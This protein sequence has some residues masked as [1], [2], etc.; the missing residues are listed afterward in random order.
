MMT[1]A[2]WFQ[3]LMLAAAGALSIAGVASGAE[4]S[5]NASDVAASLDDFEILQYIT[6]RDYPPS[7]PIGLDNNP[8]ILLACRDGASPDELR[9]SGIEFSDSQIEFLIVMNLLFR[10]GKGDLYTSFPIL[11]T[12]ET[13][14]LRAEIRSLA[15]DLAPL[16]LEDVA[17]VAKALAERGEEDYAYPLLFSYVLDGMFWGFMEEYREVPIRRLSVKRP[18]WSGGV[19]AMRPRRAFRPVTHSITVEGLT[20]K[21]V[22]TEGSSRART[23]R[24]AASAVREGLVQLAETGSVSDPANRQVLVELG[25]I[26]AGE[27]PTWSVPVVDEFDKDS[28][29]RAAEILTSN[30]VDRLIERI[31][32]ED[33]EERY[34]FRSAP[35]ALVI[36][37]HELMW[38]LLD[39]FEAAGLVTRPPAL[40][41]GQQGEQ[42]KGAATFT[43]AAFV[44]DSRP[45]KEEFRDVD[46]P[47]FVEPELRGLEKDG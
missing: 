14:K 28:V 15:A 26:D 25:V 35:E 33:L 30:L 18:F 7:L 31:D 22:S 11:D 45:P 2:G 29:F 21:V 38:D 39:H 9:A 23:L 1:K 8:E 43:G 32:L 42:Q 34:G 36:A 16:V 24:K 46:E 44:L 37:H 13:G 40:Q 47:R 17:A 27:E 19:W 10:D 20:L 3:C 5:A 12:T 41:T 4:A 6:A